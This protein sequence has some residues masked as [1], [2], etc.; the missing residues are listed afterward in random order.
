MI[1]KE[2]RSIKWGIL[3]AILTAA[4]PLSSS[5]QE[6]LSLEECY[7]TANA[8]HKSLHIARNDIESAR[9]KEREITANF[10]PKVSALGVTIH[11]GDQIQPVDYDKIFGIISPFIPDVIKNRTLMD[12]TDISFAGITMVQPIYWGGKIVTGKRMA[13]EAVALRSA[14]METQQRIIYDTIDDAYWLVVGLSSKRKLADSFVNLMKQVEHDVEL[15]VKEGVVAQ[16]D[17]LMV[18]TKLAEAEMLLETTSNSLEMSRMVLAD[19]CGLPPDHMVYTVDEERDSLLTYRPG[20]PNPHLNMNSTI[21]RLPEMRSVHSLEKV[22]Q[23][24]KKLTMAD[25]LP[26][27]AL[28]GTY[29]TSS[30]NL[31]SRTHGN[32]WGGTYHIGLALTIPISDIISGTSRLKQDDYTLQ[33]QKL[34]SDIVRD[35]LELRIHRDE[36]V[37]KHAEQQLSTAKM[38]RESAQENLRMVTLMYKEG[39]VPILHLTAAQTAWVQAGDAFIDAQVVWLT[40]HSRYSR[41]IGIPGI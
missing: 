20:I 27:L 6:R 25:M 4:L 19:R 26:H 11:S 15:L 23:L 18:K 14:M 2:K 21:D 8:H 33:N 17:L 34:A 24:R 7:K 5:A 30:P 36:V 9:A 3:G 13:A 1:I 39:L 37:L 29:G 38:R 32:G 35:K 16:S 10:F 12:V 31:W 28:V 40:A 22:L 41:D